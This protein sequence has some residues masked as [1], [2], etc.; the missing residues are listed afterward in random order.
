ML[1]TMREEGASLNYESESALSTDGRRTLAGSA[2]VA[3]SLLKS[4]SDGL[5]SSNP[6]GPAHPAAYLRSTLLQTNRLVGENSG[7]KIRH[8]DIYAAFQAHRPSLT[9]P[10]HGHS[11]GR[12]PS[13]DLSPLRC[14]ESFP[15]VISISPNR[16]TTGEKGQSDS[17][18]R[19][20][21]VHKV[22]GKFSD[23]RR[24]EVQEVRKRGACIR[25]RMLRKT[26]SGLNRSP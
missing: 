11:P 25:C 24:K 3:G 4:A 1:T 17:S 15:R 9:R 18:N 21:R 16:P 2:G 6:S 19:Y 5:T 20:S 14:L 13:Q 8:T 10:S 22:R 7:D 23:S 12:S 26:V